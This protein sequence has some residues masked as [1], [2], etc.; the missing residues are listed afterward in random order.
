MA[1]FV[2][3]VQDIEGS[4]KDYSFAIAPV[5]AEKALRGSE[6]KMDVSVPA[7]LK[8]H[9]SKSGA[10]V[11][12]HGRMN[13]QLITEC[14]RCLGDAKLPVDTEITSLFQA[15]GADFRPAPDEEELTP[16]DLDRDF[17]TGDQIALDEMVREYLLLELPMQ[18]L[19][20]ES[21]EGIPVPEHIKPPKD[22]GSK[23]AGA[24]DPRLAVL[25]KLKLP[26]KE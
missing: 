7:A 16:E 25:E 21:C 10:D 17:F 14:S 12:L 11:I 19:C 3:H 26:T 5:W 22:F 6:L 1:E 2:I 15:R 8:V 4:G 9:A 23:P 13:G 20:S 24:V 18:P